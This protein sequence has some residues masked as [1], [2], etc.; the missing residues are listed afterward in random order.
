RAAGHDLD[1]TALLRR[2]AAAALV[3]LNM[4]A[5]LRQ[6]RTAGLR[7]AALTNS[8]SM[9]VHDARVDALRPEFDC[10]VESHRV[11]MRKPERR[12]YELVCRTL[13][14]QPA[15]AILL[16]DL[17]GN[18]KPARAMGM[19][20]IKVGEP[21]LAIAELERLTGVALSR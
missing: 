21:A 15:A 16:D 4:L 18:L 3:R 1:A 2:I 5:V 17:G 13:A 19:T 8:W 14:V 9:P 6:L 20:T 11:G 10:F 12:I 7:V